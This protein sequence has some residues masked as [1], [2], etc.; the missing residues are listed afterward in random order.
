MKRFVVGNIILMLLAAASTGH[1][2]GREPALHKPHL[3]AGYATQ[4]D[5]VLPNA[6]EQSYRKIHWRTSVVR[7]IVDA[8]K[9]D[10]PV[11]IVLIPE[12]Q[13]R[14]I[15]ARLEGQAIYD[16][17]AERFVSFELLV[18]S[19]RWGGNAYNGRLDERD[20]GPA[21]MGIVLT[22]AGEGAADHIPPL[23]FKAYGWK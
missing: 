1:G 5:L 15:D 9:D 10:R 21:P 13:T 7:G 4:R 16:L 11:M 22:L 17:K 14:G 3:S 18:L 20:F 2:A 12:P 8:Q 6:R 23:F 19:E